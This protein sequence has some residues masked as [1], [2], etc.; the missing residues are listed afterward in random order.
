MHGYEKTPITEIR[1]LL[2]E[3]YG[4]D[5]TTLLQTKK[6]LVAL[7]LA[8]EDG[9]AAPRTIQITEL[10]EEEMGEPTTLDDTTQDNNEIDEDDDEDLTAFNDLE[11]EIEDGEVI[12]IEGIAE[13]LEE[14]KKEVVVEGSVK[15]PDEEYVEEKS[16]KETVPTTPY[17]NSPEWSDYL[18]SQLRPDELFEKYPRL[19]GLRRLTEIF[20]GP[21]IS[22][23]LYCHKCPD[24]KSDSSTISVKIIC[25]VNN[26]NH[27]LYKKTIVETSIA[28]ANI[29]NNSV[30]PFCYHMS[31]VSENRSEARCYRNILRINVVTAEEVNAGMNMEENINNDNG[32]ISQIQIIAIDTICKRQ[33]INV[34]EFIN[35]GS[36]GKTYSSINDIDTNTALKIIQTLNEITEGKRTKPENVGVYDNNWVK[37]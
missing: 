24:D 11:V 10:K 12:N 6:L 19:R 2:K 26:P 30:N 7:L 17:F 14:I 27:P 1:R 21:I 4:V 37:Q 23:E 36:S 28:D 8:Y 15:E 35:V 16:Q 31:S 25:S 29:N 20:I 32:K 3:K 22:K 33:D 13:V 5:E 18:I 9:T 34:F